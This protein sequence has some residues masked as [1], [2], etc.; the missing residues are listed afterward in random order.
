[1]ENFSIISTDSAPFEGTVR[2]GIRYKGTEG[3]I[4][5]NDISDR[6]ELVDAIVNLAAVGNVTAFGL[7]EFLLGIIGIAV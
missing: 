5:I 2:Y 3:T 6:K 4:E 1:M 7:D